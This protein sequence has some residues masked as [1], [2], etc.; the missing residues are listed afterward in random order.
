MHFKT[1]V[2]WQ[3]ISLLDSQLKKSQSYSIIIDYLRSKRQG[4]SNIGL[5]EVIKNRFD[6]CQESIL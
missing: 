6:I 4:Y 2:F 1:L 5:P 3:E